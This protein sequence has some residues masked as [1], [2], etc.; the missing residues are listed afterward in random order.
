MGLRRIASFVRNQDVN[1]TLLLLPLTCSAGDV[2]VCVAALVDPSSC[3]LTLVRISYHL[4]AG[5]IYR[6]ERATGAVRLRPSVGRG[7]KRR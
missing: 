5:T 6:G 4:H 7:G 2:S 3:R 1:G